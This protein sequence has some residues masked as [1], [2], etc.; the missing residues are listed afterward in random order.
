MT[1]P[2]PTRGSPGSPG[3]PRTPL[4]TDDVD[5]GIAPIDPRVADHDPTG[6]DLAS[7]IA[8]AARGRSSSR[9]PTKRQQPALDPTFSGA[10]PDRRD[11]QSAGKVLD[12]LIAEQGW[13]TE[14]S[15]YVV[16]GRWES[17]VGETVA[18]HA[19]PEGYAEGILAIRCDSTAWAAQ[20]RQLAPTIVA[21]LNAS[22]GDR[23]VTRIDVRGP[24]APSWSHGRRSV[25]G[26]RG[27]R[28]T[29]G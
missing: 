16:L 8:R 7:R 19:Q 13:S 29:Y 18:A 4:E 24:D 28:D 25:R 1:Q 3:S 2:S 10:H 9:P 20:L 22:L 21:K 26:A 12:K 17:I 5:E 27:P 14:V 6:L 23:S 15:V 11:P